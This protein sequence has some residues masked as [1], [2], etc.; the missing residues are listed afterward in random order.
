MAV[1]VRFPKQSCACPVSLSGR[2]GALMIDLVVRICLSIAG[3]GVRDLFLPLDG[4]RITRGVSLFATQCVPVS[5]MVCDS[6]GFRRLGARF[7]FGSDADTVG[8]T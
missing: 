3:L 8:C 6:P 7:L 4:S 5:G 2:S 1:P